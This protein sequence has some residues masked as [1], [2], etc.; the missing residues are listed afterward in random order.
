MNYRLID[1]TRRN[2]NRVSADIE[3][4][5]AELV[6]RLGQLSSSASAG[7]AALREEK[8][9]HFAGAA[10][11]V[12]GMKAAFFMCVNG[13]SFGIVDARDKN[14]GRKAKR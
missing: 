10:E 1:G 9:G 8:Q 3:E 12:K 7:T 14:Y 4:L 6:Q 5:K 2:L 11:E 13:I